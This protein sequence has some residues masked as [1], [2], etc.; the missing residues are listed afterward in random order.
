MQPKVGMTL[1][2][3]PGAQSEWAS[4]IHVLTAILD[5]A[6]PTENHVTFTFDVTGSTAAGRRIDVFIQDACLGYMTLPGDIPW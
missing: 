2:L 5:E 4:V 6:R 1:E 3:E